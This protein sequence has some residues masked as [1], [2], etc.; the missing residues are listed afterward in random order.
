MFGGLN[1]D[2][3]IKGDKT[4]YSSGKNISS[5]FR[6]VWKW[7]TT[8]SNGLWLLCLAGRIPHHQAT[9]MLRKRWEQRW[10]HALST[11]NDMFSAHSWQSKIVISLRMTIKPQKM[12][13]HEGLVPENSENPSFGTW[14]FRLEAKGK[15]TK[16]SGGVLSGILGIL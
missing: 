16:A 2:K 7:G 15:G 10:R 3:V 8:K 4:I 5:V 9:K 1:Y 11:R 13:Y 6:C 14:K 12:R